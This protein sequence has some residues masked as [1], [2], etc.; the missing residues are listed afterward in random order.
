MNSK[1]IY[2][3]ILLKNKSDI[4]VSIGIEICGIKKSAGEQEGVYDGK[5]K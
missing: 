4:F 5:H 1:T 3:V 2:D